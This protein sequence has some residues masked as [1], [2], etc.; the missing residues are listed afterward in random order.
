MTCR[1]QLLVFAAVSRCPVNAR[2]D[3]GDL[4]MDVVLRLNLFRNVEQERAGTATSSEV[5]GDDRNPLSAKIAIVR[6]A[7]QY[8]VLYHRDC[9]KRGEKMFVCMNCLIF[10]QAIAIEPRGSQC[11]KYMGIQAINQP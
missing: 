1:V 8:E 4:H 7:G 6:Q 2:F 9:C 11:S 5:K 3:D 10:V